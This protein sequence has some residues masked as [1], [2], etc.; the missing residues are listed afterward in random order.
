MAEVIDIARRKGKERRK[1]DARQ[2][3]KAQAVASALSCGLCP[4]RCAMCGQSVEDYLPLG[5]APYPFCE[6]C[7]EEYLAFKRLEAGDGGDDAYWHN[8]QWAAMWRNWL[9]YMEAS[10][11]FRQSPGFYRLMQEYSD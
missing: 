11:T 8:D 4:R 10:A 5:Q 6:A 7:H 9:S 2:R 3:R 1:A